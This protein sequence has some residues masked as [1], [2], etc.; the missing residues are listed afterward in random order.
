VIFSILTY[1]FINIKGN[2]DLRPEVPLTTWLGLD[3]NEKAFLSV[4]NVFVLN[5]LLFI[6]EIA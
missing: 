6:G 5:S 4:A 3:I 1:S 2:H